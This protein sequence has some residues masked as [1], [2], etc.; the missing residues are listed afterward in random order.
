[1]APA[2]RRRSASASRRAAHA[3]PPATS[4]E[5]LAGRRNPVE[6]A[7]SDDGYDVFRSLRK[8]FRQFVRW[9]SSH[10]KTV[11]LIGIVLL[12]AF[13]REE[14]SDQVPL[15][16][17]PVG[18]KVEEPNRPGV[19]FRQLLQANARAG[20]RHPVVM[21][22]GFISSALELWEGRECAHSELATAFRQRMF[23]PNMI[24]TLLRNPKC[25]L[26]HFSLN[27]ST[28][29]DPAGVRVRPDGWLGAADYLVSGFW[30]WAKMIINLADVGYEPTEL[31]MASYDWRL[32]PESLEERD[33]YFARLLRQI[34][35][36]REF[37]GE[38]VVIVSH[39][40]GSLVTAAFLRWAEQGGHVGW[41]ER[42]VEAFINIGGPMMGL[43]KAAVALVSGEVRDTAMMPSAARLLVDSHIGRCERGGCFRSWLSL[44]AMYPLSAGCRA[45]WAN[46]ATIRSASH[47]AKAKIYSAASLVPRLL[48]MGNNSGHHAMVRLLS[49]AKKELPQLP[50]SS[51]TR[52][53]CFYGVNSDSEGS[54]T[55]AEESDSAD[56]FPIALDSTR[57]DKGVTQ[58]NGDGTVPL[59]SL[60]FMCRSPFGWQSRLGSSN[61]VTVEH[62]HAAEMLDPRGGVAT[63]DHVDI[64]G[65]YRVIEDVL[66]IVTGAAADV[67]DHIISEIDD[68]VESSCN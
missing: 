46:L 48:E 33:M 23:G 15:N 28:G 43:P 65:N 58:V 59:F 37:I 2:R 68:I 10:P 49:E 6:S 62:H 17:V 47:D 41:M 22:P 39:S 57:R 55:F 64:M 16:V 38:R 67:Q 32:D 61:V 3:S 26:E 60:G 29:R 9:C 40:Y 12:L 45:S 19:H 44:A 51:T 50:S 14:V 36:M 25:F 21:V 66:R 11:L 18:M 34:E 8:S 42:N 24:V 13:F 52:V 1:M 7:E 56:G 30:V 27:Y 35:F 4:E 31:H 53:F 5:H 20:K 63:G 54:F